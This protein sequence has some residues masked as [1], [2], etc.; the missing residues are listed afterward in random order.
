[1][2]T[3][4]VRQIMPGSNREMVRKHTGSSLALA[5]EVPRRCNLG[6]DSGR[7]C[8]R[9]ANLRSPRESNKE[10]LEAIGAEVATRYRD[11]RKRPLSVAIMGQTGVGKSSLLNAM[12]AANLEVGHARPTTKQPTP[13]S[14]RSNEGHEIIFWDLPGIGESES[15]DA[16]YL[17]VYAD[18]L[19]GCDV[20]IWACHVDNRSTLQ[21]VRT[22]DALLSGRSIDQRRLLLSRLTFILTKADVLSNPSWIYALDGNSGT[23]A[24]PKAVTGRLEERER[25]FEEV[26]LA[27]HYQELVSRTYVT[28]RFSGRKLSILSEVAGHRLEIEGRE[29]ICHGYVT[30]QVEKRLL[31]RFPDTSEVWQRLRENHRVISCSSIFNYDLTRVLAAILNKLGWE[32]VARFADVIEKTENISD[33]PFDTARHLSNIVVWDRR[34]ERPI[35]DLKTA[36]IR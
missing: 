10:E 8:T 7:P 29:L 3:P 30:D 17:D 24:P 19:L 33:I 13:L 25:Y 1:M 20:A 12:F 35:Y 5:A 21:D 14:V 26:L 16:G 22:L 2:R 34:T 28:G 23:F 18:L 27:P 15:A 6:R 9:G 36:E 32:S 11:L 31:A 4:S